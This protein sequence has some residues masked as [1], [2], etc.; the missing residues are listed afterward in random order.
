M[1]TG[2]KKPIDFKPIYIAQVLFNISFYGIRSIF[3]LYAVN[4]L[5]LD[6]AQAFRFFSTF[7]TLCYGTSLIGGYMADKGLGVKNTIIA[8]GILSSLGFLCILLPIPDF[9][10]LGL[11]LSSLGSGYFKP[12]LLTAAGLLFKDPKDPQKGRVYSILYMVMNLGALVAPL[13]C[14]FVGKTYGWHYGIMVIAFIFSVSTYFVYKTMRFHPSYKEE[15]L[16]PKWQIFWGNLALIAL[17]YSLFKYQGSFH[18]LMGAITCGSILCLGR[19]FYDCNPQEKKD[20]STVMAYVLLFAF[21]CALFE[22]EATSLMLFFERA[23]DRQVGGFII[24]PSFFL[25]LGS[26]F[27]LV[28]N[29]LLLFISSR[30]LEAKKPMNGFVKVGCGFLCVGCSFGILTLGIKIN[31]LPIPL[32]WIVGALFVQTIGELWV[33]PVSFT[34]ISQHAPPRFKSTLM[35]FWSMAIAY[36]HYFSGVIAQFSLSGNILFEHALEGY[37]TFFTHL[38]LLPLCVAFPLLG[39]QTIKRI[40]S[41][42]RRKKRLIAKNK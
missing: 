10:F 15:R 36:G 5:L 35:A 38:A 42:Q 6:D 26:F 32:A 17:L 13:V 12:N 4:S 34:K 7:M 16:I 31:V 40:V 22:Q 41:K 20:L 2:N 25:S 1:A 37:G 33:A 11:A 14:G 39:Y 27:V 18:S 9:L 19:I 21:F 28:C 24:P 29:P 30:W 8:G 3:I 23:V